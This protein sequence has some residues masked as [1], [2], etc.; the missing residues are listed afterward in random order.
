MASPDLDKACAVL[1]ERARRHFGRSRVRSWRDCPRRTIRA[2]RI[3]GP[4]TG[5]SSTAWSAR[6]FAPP[7]EPVR[8]HRIRLVWLILRHAFL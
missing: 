2:P 5:R 3:M 7:R 8:I 1:I 4:P 6:G